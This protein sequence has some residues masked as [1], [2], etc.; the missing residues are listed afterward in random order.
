MTID[1]I[2]TG[3]VFT[4][5]PDRHFVYYV[6][7]ERNVL[8]VIATKDGRLLFAKWPFSSFVSKNYS[9]VEIEDR[10]W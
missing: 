7:R 2:N 9:G 5:Q 1:E 3:S 4:S 8:Q 6:K 10:T